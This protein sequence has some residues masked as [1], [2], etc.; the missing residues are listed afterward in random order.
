M[1][2]LGRKS[3]KVSGWVD[4]ASRSSI[5]GGHNAD[6]IEAWHGGRGTA[7][8]GQAGFGKTDRHLSGAPYIPI[9]SISHTFHGT[10]I[11][12]YIEVV[13]G[14]NVGIY[15]SHMECNYGYV[16]RLRVRILRMLGGTRYHHPPQRKHRILS[17]T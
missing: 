5:W 3:R 9:H 2:V 17:G 13:C 14:F 4:A 7:W 12:A 16:L 11:Y 8:G 1:G 15:S 6:E 10:G